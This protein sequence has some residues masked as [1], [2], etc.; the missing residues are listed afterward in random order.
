MRVCRAAIASN[1]VLLGSLAWPAAAVVNPPALKWA[2]GG[3]SG[4][5]G[6]YS[7]QT[8]WYASPAVADLD[9]DGQAEA[10]WGG[11][12]LAVVNGATGALRASVSNGS[13]IWPGVAVADLEGD[14][15]LEIVVGRG[16]DQL[17]VYR[18]SVNGATLTLTTLW[19]RN[20]FGGG[21]VR[22]LAVSDLDGD[23][24][25]EV[26][27][28]RASSGGTQ[29]VNVY[30]A[31]GAVR[32]GWPARR[33]GEPGFGA[34]MYNENVTVADLNGDGFK[35]VFAP[36]DTHYITALDRNGNQLGTS[37][38][39]NTSNPQ[40]PKV[41]SQVGV[42]VDQ[43][44]DLR[45]FANCGT[46]HRPNF[47]NSAPAL[48]DLDGDGSAELVVPGDVYNCG[49]G[50][51]AGDLYHLPWILK[52]DRTRWSGSGYDWTVI[53]A[54]EAGSGP[55]SQDFSVIEN[56]VQN[57]V[58]A[59]L[60]GD[61]QRE[62]LFPSY[63]GRLHA[64]WLDKTEHGAWPVTI[65]TVAGGNDTFR[66]ASE[67]AVADLDNDGQA[68]VLVASWPRKIAGLRGEL[69]IY[70]SQGALLQRVALPLP[71]TFGDS[72]NGA[73]GAPTLAN[74]DADA[75]LEVVLGTRSSGLVAYDL[76]GSANARVL[77]G[78]GRGH[79]RRTGALTPT[80]VSI[81][82][83]S[84]TEGASAVL[85]VTLARA[86]DHE[87]SVA[88]S[89]ITAG[90]TPATPGSD[91]SASSGMLVFPA[92]S[93]TRTLSVPVLGDLL[94]EPDETFG[95]ALS[96]PNGA[97]LSSALAL[98]T[99]LDDD[100]TPVISVSDASSAEGQSGWTLH[101]FNVGLNGLSAA[102][103]SVHFATAPGSASA[104]SDYQP[105][106]GG[107]T[108]APGTNALKTF[109]VP[110]SGD[111]VAES[112]ETYAV[113]FTA[114]VAA[115]LPDPQAQG[116]I[117]TDDGV[118]LSVDDVRVVEPKTGQRSLT[119]TVSLA[120]A[121]PSATV[122]VL[123]AAVGVTATAGDDFLA[124]SGTASFAPGVTTV[125]V[126]VQVLADTASEGQETLRLDLSNPS[127]AV[128]AA[129]SGVGTLID[130]Q[131]GGD[132]DAD[133]ESDI[134]WRHALSGRNVVWLMNGT[135]R[136][137]GLLT[138]PDTRDAAW[139]IVGTA[140]IDGDQRSDVLW[141]HPQSGALDVWFMNGIAQTGPTQPLSPAGEPDTNWGV[142]GTGDFDQN[143]SP[144]LFWRNSATGALRLWLM[145]GT[146]RLGETATT[147]AALT[148]LGWVVVGVGDFSGDGRPDV[149]WRHLLSGKNVVWVMNGAVR[150]LGLFTTPDAFTDLNWK[151]AAVGDYDQDGWPDI[152]WRHA[153]SGRNVVW[154]MRGS[155]RVAGVFTTPDQLADANWQIVGPR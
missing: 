97:T 146:T 66:F 143:G 88:W 140:D 155:V 34:G 12:N 99:I 19:T 13:R 114:P 4:S 103:V 110:V 80:S 79:L 108:W 5:P 7:C 30:N 38:L 145:S 61:G 113:D 23:G 37:A 150:E 55:R 47:A 18:P 36:T 92:G 86:V 11:S 43:A 116:A 132:F 64:F 57:A 42:H 2:Y 144:D 149:L 135:V 32:A 136:E 119:F 151:M 133:G 109:W 85:S 81:A 54:A 126:A 120:P 94:D 154:H 69:L 98:V 60:D 118:G 10:I 45:G 102:T 77:W 91:Y 26:I 48:A 141:R 29:Q 39:Y 46:E 106:A 148:D 3:C 130:A 71:A 139:R 50:D 115:H 70:S 121:N 138:N 27:V 128:I 67:P 9:G 15:T 153:L 134:L 8:G 17:A 87:V 20:P 62:I 51:P 137:A 53:P 75:D 104:T 44:A 21:E 90:A 59:D 40:G 72:W 111:R 68:E 73:L 89:T 117:V 25:L 63:D 107:L 123:W 125:P 35:E 6:N 124:A 33:V 100:P 82:G 131:V 52:L 142:V 101:A 49:I 16:A 56:D 31:N 84:V 122:T 83:A 147:P 78:T 74:V 58:L 76:P 105:I 96:A 112:D 65:P 24:P 95:V 152:L 14:G 127:G 129:A 41:W 22:T 28:G 1:A 93:S